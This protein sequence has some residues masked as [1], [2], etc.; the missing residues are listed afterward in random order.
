[1]EHRLRTRS[2]DS[3]E[4]IKERIAKAE[5]EMAYAKDFDIVLVNDKLETAKEEA[6][7]LIEKFVFSS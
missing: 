3:E 7:A 4:K 5:R 2:T 1:M 6:T